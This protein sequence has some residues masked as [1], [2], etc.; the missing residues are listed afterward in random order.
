MWIFE[1]SFDFLPQI[2]PESSL[3]VK[4]Y[5]EKTIQLKTTFVLES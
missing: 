2:A 1:L 5:Q 3:N 4:K